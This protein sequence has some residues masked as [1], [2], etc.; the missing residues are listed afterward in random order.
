MYE[1]ENETFFKEMHNWEYECMCAAKSGKSSYSVVM[2][3]I[4]YKVCAIWCF[5]HGLNFKA[6]ALDKEQV[7]FTISWV[8]FNLIDSENEE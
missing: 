2:P 5:Y 1:H 8:N 7:A 4:L 3:R 6:S